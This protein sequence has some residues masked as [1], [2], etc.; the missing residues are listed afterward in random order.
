MIDNTEPSVKMTLEQL[1]QLEVMETRTGNLQNE[2]KIATKTLDIT[3][4]DL[5]RV[6]KEKVYQEGLLKTVEASVT[7]KKAELDSLNEKINFATVTL[8]EKTTLSDK[9]GLANNAKATEL[10]EK[11]ATLNARIAEH[12]KNA[13]DLAESV[14]LHLEDKTKVSKLKEDLTKAFSNFS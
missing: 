8:S 2:A 4:N 12:D 3:R 1:K 14:C 13:S 6:T 9:V 5:D 10:L 7:E 11:E